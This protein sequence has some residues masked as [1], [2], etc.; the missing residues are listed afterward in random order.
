MK[1]SN[2]EPITHDGRHDLLT[3]LMAPPH[4]YEAMARELALLKRSFIELCIIRI[5]IPINSNDEEIINFAD[6]LDKSVRIEDLAARVGKFEFG[7]L[8][9]GDQSVVEKFIARIDFQIELNYSSTQVRAG[10]ATLELLN[11]LDQIELSR[12][13]TAFI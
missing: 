9:R 11:R 10:E 7:L 2:F 12:A 3:N 1:S 4:Y 5:V 8:V 6:A 13:T